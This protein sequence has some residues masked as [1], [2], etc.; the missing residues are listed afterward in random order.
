MLLPKKKNVRVC[1]CAPVDA[2]THTS[3]D[4]Y[5]YQLSL[6]V[7]TATVSFSRLVGYKEA[8]PLRNNVGVLPYLQA[9]SFPT[10]PAF[11]DDSFTSV[12]L[13]NSKVGDAFIQDTLSMRCPMLQ[14]SLSGWRGCLEGWAASGTRSARLRSTVREACYLWG[15]GIT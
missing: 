8:L 14:V 4:S 13:V 5:M 10:P 1:V 3:D 6:V 7:A 9:G 11:L 15:R 12:S 2:H